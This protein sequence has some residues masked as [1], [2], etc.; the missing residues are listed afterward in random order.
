GRASLGRLENTRDGLRDARV[1]LEFPAELFGSRR[2]HLVVAG[3]A[4][5]RSLAPFPDQPSLDHHALES[6][7]ERAL[8][9]VQDIAGG[10]LDRIRDLETVHL[11]AAGQ[12]S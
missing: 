12:G 7:V 4:V 2:G 9:D 5:F 8:L 1:L 10:L 6:R 3:T 11:A